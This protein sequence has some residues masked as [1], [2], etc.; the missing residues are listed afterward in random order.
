MYMVGNTL[1]SVGNALARDH[2]R[3]DAASLDKFRVGALL[4]NS[5]ALEHVDAV[6][7]LDGREAVRHDQHGAVQSI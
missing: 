2:A 1:A 5:T 6:A 3:V 4:D 7:G